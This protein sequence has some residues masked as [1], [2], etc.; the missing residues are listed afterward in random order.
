MQNIG[1]AEHGAGRGWRGETMGWG[2]PA[3]AVVLERVWQEGL[4]LVYPDSVT[5]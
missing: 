3:S 1:S 5:Q 4:R 2:G